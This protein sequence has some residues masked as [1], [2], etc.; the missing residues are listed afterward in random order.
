MNLIQS[1]NS[2]LWCSHY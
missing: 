2:K 1:K